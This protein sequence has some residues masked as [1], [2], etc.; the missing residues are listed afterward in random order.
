MPGG[1][2]RRTGM[3]GDDFIRAAHVF[4][5]LSRLFPWRQRVERGRVVQAHVAVVGDMQCPIL[6]DVAVHPRWRLAR[7]IDEIE[8]QAVDRQA[9]AACSGDVGVR[10]RADD[11][12]HGPRPPIESPLKSRLPE[13]G[14]LSAIDDRDGSCIAEAHVDHRQRRFDHPS[15]ALYA[16][17]WVGRRKPESM[18][19]C[20]RALLSRRCSAAS[21]PTRL[22]SS[23]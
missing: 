11:R 17:K 12:H 10:V 19:R 22:T 1:R 7:R 15:A 3:P 23:S 20:F 16:T 8:F 13:N 14:E 18:T 6:R 4:E 5:C 21:L 9:S 2:L